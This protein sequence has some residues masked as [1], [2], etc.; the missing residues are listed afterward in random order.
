[1]LITGEKRFNKNDLIRI[2]KPGKNYTKIKSDINK[3][4]WYM[5]NNDI[6]DNYIG[7]NPYGIFTIRTQKFLK[8]EKS[9][10]LYLNYKNINNNNLSIYGYDNNIIS[11]FNQ[12]KIKDNL[13]IDKS[14]PSK[15]IY[16]YLDDNLNNIISLIGNKINYFNSLSL[17]LYK[18]RKFR[19]YKT[20][21]FIN[22]KEFIE[23]VNFFN[24]IDLW[25]NI[26]IDY[27]LQDTSVNQDYKYEVILTP[28]DLMNITK[29][30]TSFY[31]NNITCLRYW[32]DIDLKSIKRDKILIRDKYDNLYIL[33]YDKGT[34]SEDAIKDSSMSMED[35]RKFYFRNL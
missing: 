8:P 21:K 26:C 6:I 1:M 7:I 9:Y 10:G 3:K 35:M 13:Y 19:S 17:N 11:I 2:I 27:K 5:K 12:G 16:T 15:I 28:N 23:S 31:M 22:L 18:F 24:T 34:I 25:N 32:Y 20:N 33:V 30:A 4:E 29:K 14:K